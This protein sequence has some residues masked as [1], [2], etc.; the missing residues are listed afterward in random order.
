MSSSIGSD[1]S[2][3][4]IIHCHVDAYAVNR[5]TQLARAS[6]FL[7]HNSDY[8]INI[9]PPTRVILSESR[10]DAQSRNHYKREMSDVWRTPASESGMVY[11]RG[12]K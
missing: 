11:N 5:L 8:C 9:V 2:K 12:L 1:I 7:T 6:F 4:H 10:L 3:V